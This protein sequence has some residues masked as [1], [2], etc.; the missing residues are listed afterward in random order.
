MW[1]NGFY[2]LRVRFYK[3]GGS[4]QSLNNFT[5]TILVSYSFSKYST[6][7]RPATASKT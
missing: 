2:F 5:P 4:G 7:L 6:L 1:F 3:E